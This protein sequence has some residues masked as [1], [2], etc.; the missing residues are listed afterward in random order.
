MTETVVI[1]SIDS[2]MKMIGDQKYNNRIGR[3]RSTYYYRGMPDA[4]FNL[5]TSLRINCKQLSHRL[6]PSILKAFSN[7]ASIEDPSISNSVWKQM[8]VGQHHGL[9]TRLMDW[10]YS[11]LIALHF[12]ESVNDLEKLSDCDCVVWRIDINDC[13]KNLPEKYRSVLAKNEK[14]VFSVVALT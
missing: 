5:T 12:A 1:D 8:M 10:T 7:Y 6:E 13:N 2:V 14:S 4:S 11:P 3:L 9:P